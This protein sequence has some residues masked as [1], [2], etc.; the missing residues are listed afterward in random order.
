MDN[1]IQNP[2]LRISKSKIMKNLNLY[3]K[4]SNNTE[5]GCVLKSNA[6]GCGV[7]EVAKFLNSEGIKTFF[8]ATNEE[9]RQISISLNRNS[10]AYVLSDFW[11]PTEKINKTEVISVLS[12]EKE[13]LELLKNPQYITESQLA[14]H[15]DCGLNRFGIQDSQDFRRSIEEIISHRPSNILILAHLSHADN[16]NSKT[17]IDQL[18]KLEDFRN[19]FTDLQ[20]SISGSAAVINDEMFSLDL[21]RPGIS[22]FGGE[23]SNSIRMKKFHNAINLRAPILQIKALKK[24]EGVGYNHKFKAPKKTYVATARIGYADGIDRKLANKLRVYIGSKVFKLIGSISMDLITF[25]VDKNTYHDFLKSRKVIYVDIINDKQ[26][27]ND[28]SNYLGTIPNEVLT[29]ISNRVERK[30][31]R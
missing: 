7:N 20:Y 2:E 28:I 21:I 4:F 15:L 13:L 17:N 3:K 24:G 14:F 8:L 22:L 5:I 18:T 1:S 30:L 10:K 16:S 19:E 11:K 12:T 23:S 31:V 9:A 6:Y 25:Q 29:T 27:P 26:T